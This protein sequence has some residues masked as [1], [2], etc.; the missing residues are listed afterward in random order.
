MSNQNTNAAER[1]DPMDQIGLMR[2]AQLAPRPKTLQETGLSRELLIDLIAKHFLDRGTLSLSELSEA[3]ALS[4]GILEQVLEFMRGEALT[5]VRPARNDKVGLIY[6][7]TD[8]GRS[9]ALDAMNRSGY[10]GPAPVPL[11][12]YRK[13]TEAQSVHRHA[14]TRDNV[15]RS[16][17]DVVIEPGLLDRIGASVNSGRAIF[18]YGD[19]GTGKTYISQRLTRLFPGLILLPHA[20]AIDNQVVQVFDPLMHKVVDVNHSDDAVMLG[21]GHDRRFAVCERPAVITAG[22]LSADMLEVAFEPTAKLYEAPLQMRAN[23]GVFIIDDLGRQHIEPKQLFNRWIVPLE[24]KIDYLSLKSGK[25]FSVP[26]DVVLVFSTNIHPLKLADEAFL[27]RIGYKIEFKPMTPDAY[28]RVW[29][30]TCVQLEIDYDAQVLQFVINELHGKHNKP[31]L[32]C[33][34]RDLIGM[35]VDHSLY[36]DNERYID[37]EK[38]VW[39]W[40]N[41][42]V[43]LQD[44]S[45]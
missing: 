43:S 15:Y 30:D 45:E 10:V 34:P 16:F 4:G 18:L 19:A 28:Q 12:L 20:V 8:R 6:G 26:F 44:F 25:H 5:E 3:T 1:S 41:Y 17:T 22:E 35:A 32:P 21:R 2:L 23:N 7:L 11:H 13:V 40:N 27:R 38:M 36:V 37:C 14:V 24:E 9:A 42:F 33:H 31:L 29:H 39:A